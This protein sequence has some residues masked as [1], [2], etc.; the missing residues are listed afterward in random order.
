MIRSMTAFAH[1]GLR[2]EWGELSW[3]IRSLNHRY[4]EVSTRLPEELRPLE[5]GVRERVGKLLG[6]GKVEC[7]LRFQRATALATT[8]QFNREYA[9]RLIELH[10]E[11]NALVDEPAILRPID[12]LRWPGVVVETGADLESLTEAAFTL[13]EQTLAE[14]IVT[15][16]REGQ[17]LQAVI[18][19]RCST[20]AGIVVQVRDQLPDIRQQLRARLQGRL[21]EL[22]IES[23]PGR[24]EQEMVIQ[25]QKMDVDEELDRLDTHVQEIRKVLKREEPVGRRLDFLMQ[26][27]NREA[28]TLGSKSIAMETGSAAVELKVLIEQIREQVQNIE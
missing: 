27:L 28:N 6:R 23:E 5:S 16:E 22:G 7:N 10:A 1:C 21:Q 25:L 4:L 11:A 2:E 12:L 20:I 18:E 17:Q 19:Q 3:E 26:E 14:L 13:L 9:Q 24:L 8:L 15:R